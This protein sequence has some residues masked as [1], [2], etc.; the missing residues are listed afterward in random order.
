MERRG[1]LGGLAIAG[2]AFPEVAP[3]RAAVITNSTAMHLNHFLE[4]LGGA[5]GI[6]QVALV[7]APPG[8]DRCR[9]Q[10]GPHSAS[11]QVFDEQRARFAHYRPHFIATLEP[12]RMRET[13]HAAIES[14]SHVLI[15]KPA[16]ARLEQM[17]PAIDAA[18]ARAE[19]GTMETV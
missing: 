19:N 17:M 18:G 2:A 16:C 10:L 9:K 4:G 15:E 11:T 3:N 13:A 6:S 14:S 7:G 5:E 8:I 1:F 12:A